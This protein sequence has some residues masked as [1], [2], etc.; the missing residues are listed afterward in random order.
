MSILDCTK[1]RTVVAVSV[2][3]FIL[4]LVMQAPRV[5]MD[6]GYSYIAVLL[7]GT[8]LLFVVLSPVLMISAALLALMPGISRHLGLCE[9]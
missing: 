3:L 8:G 6:G 9:R 5:F 4:G 2:A 1:L 7:S